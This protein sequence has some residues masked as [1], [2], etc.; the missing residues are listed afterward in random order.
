[1]VGAAAGRRGAAHGP[2]FLCLSSTFVAWSDLN[3]SRGAVQ[4]VTSNWDLILLV[5]DDKKHVPRPSPK[6]CILFVL[7]LCSV[8]ELVTVLVNPPRFSI[9]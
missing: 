3:K 5:G 6:L 9:V 4:K 2:L 1:M 8:T 7:D